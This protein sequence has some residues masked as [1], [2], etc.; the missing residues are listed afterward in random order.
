M[1]CDTR[2]A[3]NAHKLSVTLT[4]LAQISNHQA[5]RDYFLTWN[6]CLLR[7]SS[8]AEGNKTTLLLTVNTP[9]LFEGDH[10]KQQKDADNCFFSSFFLNRC[11][12]TVHSSAESDSE[13]HQTV[14]TS[15]W[16]K[17]TSVSPVLKWE[18]EV[19]GISKNIIPDTYHQSNYQ[20]LLLI[21]A[22]VTSAVMLLGGGTS[23][24][25]A[26]WSLKH[27]EN[28][29]KS[30]SVSKDK[31]QWFWLFLF[32]DFMFIHV[33]FKFFVGEWVSTDLQKTYLKFGLVTKTTC[34]QRVRNDKMFERKKQQW[35]EK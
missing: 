33:W 15:L 32:W 25:T 3:A 35:L 5:T 26:E 10:A 31:L 11:L 2:R 19:Q 6:F 9:L 24:I 20:L 13:I 29:F 17:A 27:P 23:C 7:C 21:A 12:Q 28:I 16:Q 34:W 4:E 22:A 8:G 30:Y 18:T 1:S 14:L